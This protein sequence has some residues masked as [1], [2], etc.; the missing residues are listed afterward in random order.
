MAMQEPNWWDAAPVVSGAPPAPVAQPRQQQAPAP[1][2]QASPRPQIRFANDEDALAR[3]IA[4]E[5]G[6]EGEQGMRAVGEVVYNRSQRRGKGIQDVVTEPYQF[7]PWGNAETTQR[8]LNMRTDDPQY[9][10]ALRVAREV[11]A[12]RSNVTGGA[13]HFYAPELQ[14][15]LG[16]DRPAFDNGRGQRIGNQLFFNLEGQGGNT[17]HQNSAPADDQEW[18]QTAPVVNQVDSVNQEALDAMNAANTPAPEARFPRDRPFMIREGLTGDEAALQT[19]TAYSIKKGDWVQEPDGTIYQAAADAYAD[20]NAPRND[21]MIGGTG[22]YS[23]TPDLEDS[24][25]AF[26][27]AAAEQVPFLDEAATA[28][29][30]GIEG[31]SYSDVRD[32]YRTMVDI[33]NQA[34]RT[35]RVAGGLTGFAGTLAVPV[36]GANQFV[37][38]GRGALGV[39]GRASLL[40]AGSGA[41]QGAAMADGGLEDRAQA[42]AVG[43]LL[44]AGLAPIAV[45]GSNLVQAAA[46]RVTSGFS[47]AGSRI[48]G[49]FGRQAPEAEITPAATEEAAQYVRRLIGERDITQSPAGLLGKPITTAEAIG[50]SGVSQAT[51]L[52]RRSGRAGELAL[53]VLGPRTEEQGARI[54]DDVAKAAGVDPSVAAGNIQALAQQGRARAAPLYE[55]AY[56]QENVFSPELQNLMTR[57]SMQRALGNAVDIILEEGGDPRA[58]GI[59]AREDGTFEPLTVPTMQTWDYIKRGLDDV[60]EESRDPTTRQLNLDTRGRAADQTRTALRNEL[61]NTDQPWGAAYRAALDAGGDAPRLMTA[62]NDGARLFSTTTREQDFTRRVAAMGEEERTAAIAGIVDDLYTKARNNRLNLRHL[63]TPAS[64]A[65]LTQ[66]IGEDGANDLVARVTAEQELARTGGRMMPGT[67]STTGEVQEAIRE[68]DQ[69]VGLLGML[70]RNI[71]QSGPVGGTL[72]TGVEAVSAPVAG[73]V[74][75][76]QAPAPQATRDEIQRLL[77]MPPEE[78]ARLLGSMTPQ[79]RRYYGGLLSTPTGQSS[80]LLASEMQ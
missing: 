3:T 59:I 47:E 9:Q 79:Q 33:D 16:R 20:P 37:S 71:E 42:G 35:S 34:N 65:K 18:W 19:N 53:D 30:A 31:R 25:R 11:L 6:G 39:G 38:A 10:A 80:G 4:G 54:I 55:A 22:I 70:S 49:L 5:A 51:A 36:K 1:R 28:A 63:R 50:P 27:S 64:R 68:Q 52:S 15:Q 75:G 14:A 77:M 44:G 60:I 57:P 32:N 29:V 56:A 7:E 8:L 41:I 48:G 12:G 67:N 66:L 24:A 61:T 74:R 76:V 17:A 43:G 40:G 2:R 58:L 23:R 21:T 13:D 72:R 69:G 26:V 45:G 73:F 62:F 78:A 46:P